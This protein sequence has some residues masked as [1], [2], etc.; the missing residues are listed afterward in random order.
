[1][2]SV[3]IPTCNRIDLLKKCLDNLHSSMQSVSLELYEIIV[4]DDSKENIAKN[5]LSKN[6]YWVK[7]VEGPKKGPAANRNNGAKNASG[8]WLIFIDD[9]CIP[10]QNLLSEYLS[11]INK[12][13]GCLAFEGAIYP[14]DEKLLKKD[15]AE[16]PVNTSG[17]YF[18][19]ANICIHANLFKEVGG[20]D[21]NYLI[22]AQEDQDIYLRIL[23]RTNVFFLNKCIVIHPVRIASLQKKIKDFNTSCKNYAVFFAKNKRNSYFHEMRKNLWVYFKKSLINLVQFRFKSAVFNIIS[24]CMGV[25]VFTF[26]YLKLKIKAIRISKSSII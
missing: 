19:S 21:E 4:T 16:C 1:M 14:N 17:G 6:Y 11:G 25:P 10:D 24:I 15:M 26:F 23:P 2:L 8:E 18:W 5:L 13:P 22:A 3:I 12:N 20:F 7:W 9:D